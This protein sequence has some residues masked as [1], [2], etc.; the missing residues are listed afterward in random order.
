MA[1]RVNPRLDLRET[2]LDPACGTGGFLT[3]AID[4]L[5]HQITTKSSAEDTRAI[6]TLIHG[7]E[8]KQ[9]PHLLCTTNMLPVSYTHLDVYKRQELDYLERIVS[10]YLDFGELQALRKIP[11]TMADWAKRLDGF[12]E[13][14][15]NQILTGPGK[16]SHEQAKLHAE[17][18]FEKYRIVQDGLF[19]S[20]FD[21]L[22]RAAES[23]RLQ[24]PQAP[25]KLRKKK[26]GEA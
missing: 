13:F 5:R 24:T 2:V 26:G 23:M 9:L 6:E 20:D 3:A 1:D 25:A 10:V 18:E 16:F 21:R 8:K 11:M 12:L 19:E 14:N 4:H 15:G 7:I 22:L 17:T